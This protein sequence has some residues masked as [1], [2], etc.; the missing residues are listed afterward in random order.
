[1]RPGDHEV[2]FRVH[3]HVG[4]FLRRGRRAVDAER[5]RHVLAEDGNLKSAD[6][7]DPENS[8][9]GGECPRVHVGVAAGVVGPGDDEVAV[10]IDRHAAE[11]LDAAEQFRMGRGGSHRHDREGVDSRADHVVVPVKQRQVGRR[12]VGVVAPHEEPIPAQGGVVGRPDHHVVAIGVDRHRVGAFRIERAGDPARAAADNR[13][14]GCIDLVDVHRER[15]PHGNAAGRRTK[16]TQGIARQVAQARN[17]PRSRRR[18][19]RDLVLGAAERGHAR[20]QAAVGVERQ[21]RFPLV[22]R[23]RRELVGPAESVRPAG[24]LGSLVQAELDIDHAEGN[25]HAVLREHPVVRVQHAVRVFRR[26]AGQQR[27]IER[28]DDIPHRA[29]DRAAVGHEVALVIDQVGHPR[30]GCVDALV[31]PPVVNVLVGRAVVGVRVAGCVP[32]ALLI[33]RPNECEIASRGDRHRD[34]GLGGP[35]IGRLV[36]DD[37]R[38][39]GGRRQAVC[40]QLECDVRIVDL[41]LERDLENDGIRRSRVPP[42]LRSV[43]E[44]HLP[45]KDFLRGNNPHVDNPVVLRLRPVDARPRRRLQLVVNVVARRRNVHHVV[46]KH[47]VERDRVEPGGKRIVEPRRE[48]SAGGGRVDRDQVLRVVPVALGVDHAVAGEDIGGAG[49]RV[50]VEA[51]VHHAVGLAAEQRGLAVENRADPAE[52]RQGGA[53]VGRIDQHQLDRRVDVDVAAQRHVAAREEHQQIGVCRVAQSLREVAAAEVETVRNV[54]AET[55]V[56]DHQVA[57]GVEAGSRVL[58]R[59][60]P[61]RVGSQI[62]TRAVGA[63]GVADNRPADVS[64]RVEQL[65]HDRPRADRIPAHVVGILERAGLIGHDEAVLLVERRGVVDTG[66]D[67]ER[68]VDQVA[69]GVVDLRGDRQARVPGDHG[70]AVVAHAHVRIAVNLRVFRVHQEL[71]GDRRAVASELPRADAVEEADVLRGGRPADCEIAVVVHADRGIDLRAG[72]LRIDAECVALGHDPRHVS[73]VRG[74]RQADRREP[75]SVDVG[76]VA[77][78][79]RFADL[80]LPGNHEIA[81][82]VHRHHG[83]GLIELVRIRGE[84]VFGLF[85]I[86]AEFRARLL[87]RHDIDLGRGDPRSPQLVDGLHDH[88]LRVVLLAGVALRAAGDLAVESDVELRQADRAVRQRHRLHGNVR[89]ALAD[90]LRL[91]VRPLEWRDAARRFELDRPDVETGHRLAEVLLDRPGRQVRVRR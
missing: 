91:G 75:P 27:F 1:M 60:R 84:D 46:G 23:D 24:Q 57:V 49:R 45:G 9:A 22:R 17:P 26:I 78:I 74:S 10:G 66:A 88:Q 21:D 83:V 81:V 38:R 32:G 29:L 50:G 53:L 85:G 82:G 87:E 68:P 70:V 51:A 79:L 7:R 34:V 71:V 67:V 5:L 43:G 65:V 16:R 19:R 80:A 15:P 77:R 6:V 73:D 20:H 56:G 35:R 11:S 86:D 28:N 4:P 13:V 41:A 30:P 62:E 72:G 2:A 33:L 44:R 58:L 61:E 89:H 59:S 3:R 8:G 90:C 31:E 37:L 47:R 64:G 40:T 12:A 76:N 48:R 69:L 54:R 39:L 63:E 25:F 36:L 42:R 14:D 18:E 55:V 52:L